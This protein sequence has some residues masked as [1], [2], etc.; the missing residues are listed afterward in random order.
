MVKVLNKKEQLSQIKNFMPK[1]PPNNLEN[2][3]AIGCQ[4]PIFL[5]QVKTIATLL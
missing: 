2:H 3:F 5:N 4:F 1:I